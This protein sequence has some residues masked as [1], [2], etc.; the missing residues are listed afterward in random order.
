[1]CVLCVG[2]TVLSESI[3][4]T[5]TGEIWSPITKKNTGGY[6]MRIVQNKLLEDMILSLFLLD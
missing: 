3:S 4:L 1:M 6:E 5:E 2:Q